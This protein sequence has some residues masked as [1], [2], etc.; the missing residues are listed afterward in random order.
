MLSCELTFIQR[1]PNLACFDSRFIKPFWHMV[2]II[3]I[4]TTIYISVKSNSLA[5][6]SQ[7]PSFFIV[8]IFTQTII[9]YSRTMIFLVDWLFQRL[10]VF[11]FFIFTFDKLKKNV[12]FKNKFKY[13]LAFTLLY[14]FIV[15]I[16]D[17]LV[18]VGRFFMDPPNL[19]GDGKFLTGWFQEDLQSSFT[20]EKEFCSRILKDSSTNEII[21]TTALEQ[22][23]IRFSLLITSQSVYCV[24]TLGHV[25]F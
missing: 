4:K 6:K 3:T 7:Y 21:V 2:I 18:Y 10:S 1:H 14:L 5:I 24:P 15:K 22:N 11:L 19:F 23:Y 8:I 25:N 13:E 16:N 9:N 20:M 12:L 17:I